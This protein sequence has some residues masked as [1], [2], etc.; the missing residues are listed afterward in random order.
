MTAQISRSEPA[1]I[2]PAG[3]V[4]LGI[5]TLGAGINWPVQK[6]L[7]GEWPPLSAR[8]LSGLAGACLLGVLAI[9]TRQSLRVPE[10]QWLRICISAFLNI[11]SWVVMMGFAL[12]ILPAS[13]AAILAYTMPVWTAVLA[14]PVLGERLTPLRVVAMIMAFAGIVVLMGGSGVE[15]SVAKLPGIVLA[16]AT[17]LTYALGTIYLKRFPIAM[18]TMA[19]ASWQLG[20][21]CLPVAVVGFAIERPD[22]AALSIVGWACLAYN[23]IVQQCIGYACW[24][25]ALQRM[26]ASA[27]AIGTMFV[28]VIGVLVSAYVIGEPLGAAQIAALV[29]T[30][31]SVALAVR[32]RV[33]QR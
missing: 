5:M 13:E 14:W 1:R 21:G 4:F 20:V 31:G 16:L 23:A 28:P 30:V 17:A 12:T 25:A 6:I 33:R 9:A 32:S 18:P 26:P 10:G 15:A 11:T 27:A 24:L 8:G 29:L 2:A 22:I 19:S 3:L 7:L